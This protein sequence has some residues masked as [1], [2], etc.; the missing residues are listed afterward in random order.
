MMNNV[1]RGKA[2]ALDGM[3]DQMFSLKRDKCKKTIDYCS[4]CQKKIAFAKGLL[5]KE[6]WQSIEN[7]PHL[8]G[9]MVA[10]NKKF[11]KIPLVYEY[12][13]IVIQSC[14]IKFL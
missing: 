9:R 6:Y 2:L 7:N 12:R 13:P 14:V 1:K 4:T 8:I 11:P 10:L 5:K 3:S